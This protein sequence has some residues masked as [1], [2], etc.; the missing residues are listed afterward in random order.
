MY[1][2]R[3][4]SIGLVHASESISGP[5]AWMCAVKPSLNEETADGDSSTEWSCGASRLMDSS[6]AMTSWASVRECPRRTSTPLFTE[7]RALLDPGN[8]GVPF[9]RRLLETEAVS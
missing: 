7:A 8:L 2:I 9:F 4:A 1:G 6:Y 3:P 5:S